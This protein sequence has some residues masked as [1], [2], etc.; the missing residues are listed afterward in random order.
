MRCFITDFKKELLFGDCY[1]EDGL[2][3]YSPCIGARIKVKILGMFWITYKQF[4][5]Q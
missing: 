5:K 1:F 3:W 4:K 2:S